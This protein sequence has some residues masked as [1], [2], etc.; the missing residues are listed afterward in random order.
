MR[1]VSWQEIPELEN[2][3][4]LGLS[5]RTVG[6]TLHFSS[7]GNLQPETLQTTSF[8]NRQPDPAFQASETAIFTP[9]LCSKAS[10]AA[11]RFIRLATKPIQERRSDNT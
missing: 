9:D 7:F 11:I 1:T 2:L 6:L 5:F 8:A 3:A 10:L 4:K